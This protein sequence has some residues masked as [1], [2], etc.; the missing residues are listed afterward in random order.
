MSCTPLER[1]LR[2]TVLLIRIIAFWSRVWLGYWAV[3]PVILAIIC[4]LFN[5]KIF[6]APDSFD[7]RVSKA[8]LSERIWM[9]RYQRPVSV[10]HQNTPKIFL[11]SPKL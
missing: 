11:Y 4:T 1:H 9:N 5:P 6:S 2:G 10:H 7:H 3:I 8:V